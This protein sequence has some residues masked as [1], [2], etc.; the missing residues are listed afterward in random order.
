MLPGLQWEGPGFPSPRGSSHQR[1][2]QRAEQPHLRTHELAVGRA[3]LR[4]GPRMLSSDS[5]QQAWPPAVPE[6]ETMPAAGG[7]AA[8]AP[9]SLQVVVSF[10]SVVVYTLLPNLDED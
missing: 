3:P 10:H 2:G 6:R 1:Q 7:S 5:T 4:A 9:T 8:P